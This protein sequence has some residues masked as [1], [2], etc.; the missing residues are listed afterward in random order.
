MAWN[1]TPREKYKR[2]SERYESDLTDGEWRMI[3]PLL[4]APSKLGRRRS[5]DLRAV[6]DAIQ[7]ML[8]TGCQWWAMPKCFPPFTTVQNDFLCMAR[9]RR[10]GAHDGRAARSCAGAGWAHHVADGRPVGIR[11]R[12]EDQGQEAPCHGGRGRV[13]DRAPGS[14]GRR[15]GPGRRA[16]RHPSDAGEGTTGEAYL[17]W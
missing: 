3:E 11:R 2:S 13:P 8:A 4:P 5:V 17:C 12:Q 1:Q 16:G 14:R 10:A 9:R 7:Y 15:A 6:F